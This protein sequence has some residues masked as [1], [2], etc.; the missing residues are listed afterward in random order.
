[1]PIRARRIRAV[2]LRQRRE[3]GAGIR[4]DV[5]DPRRRERLEIELCSK[6]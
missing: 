4:E 5:V 3:V 6:A 2:S 1:M